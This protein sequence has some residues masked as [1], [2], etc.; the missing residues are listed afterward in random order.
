MITIRDT[1]Q[2]N[3]AIILDLGTEAHGRSMVIRN[4]D[5]FKLGLKLVM[6]TVLG[7]V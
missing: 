5:G 1:N 4:K 3:K 7:V 2:S 6:K